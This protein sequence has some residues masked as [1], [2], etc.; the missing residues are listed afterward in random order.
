M[1]AVTQGSCMRNCG[2][3]FTTGSSQRNRPWSTS[4]ASTAA[5]MALLLEAILNS[6]SVVTGSPL[7]AASSP[8]ATTAA[9][10][11]SSMTPTAMPGRS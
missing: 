9:T 1:L 3:C 2:R 4:R 11:P 8:R 5:V 10:L 6:A 7:P